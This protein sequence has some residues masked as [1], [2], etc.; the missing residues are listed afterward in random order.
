[1][2]LVNSF[3]MTRI[4]YGVM[5]R[6]PGSTCDM[7]TLL[8]L[9]HICLSFI[10]YYPGNV[11][12]SARIISSHKK[13]WGSHWRELCRVACEKMS[14]WCY[15]QFGVRPFN[16]NLSLKAPEFRAL[17]F[18]TSLGCVLADFLTTLSIIRSSISN[19]PTRFNKALLN[20]LSVFFHWLDKDPS[21]TSLYLKT[22][23][24]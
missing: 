20:R 5:F 6:T 17:N 23:K 15:L 14:I 9:Y 7:A 2:F 18:I 24:H 3:S 11:A 4:Y 22:F 12:C 16:L 8:C 19:V 1:M 10:V 21:A 13:W